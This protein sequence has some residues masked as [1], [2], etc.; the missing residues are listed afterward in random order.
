MKY[1]LDTL[2]PLIELLQSLDFQV[3]GPVAQNGA[4]MYEKISS[5]E[6]LP[7]GYVDEQEGG[8][9]RLKFNDDDSFF[10]YVVGPDSWKRFLFSREEVLYSSTQN[11]DE[12]LFSTSHTKA[13]KRAFFGI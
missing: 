8:H 3:I 11:D 7:R 9:Y 6:D 12:I 2:A 5:A 4:I 1:K 10:S 13:Q